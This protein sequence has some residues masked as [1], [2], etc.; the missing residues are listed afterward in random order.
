MMGWLHSSLVHTPLEMASSSGMKQVSLWL[1][2]WSSDTE[3]PRQ[4]LCNRRCYNTDQPYQTLQSC[5]QSW[6]KRWRH[7]D[8]VCIPQS[9]RNLYRRNE[10]FPKICWEE[11]REWSPDTT[12]NKRRGTVAAKRLLVA[13]VSTVDYERGFSRQNLIKTAI[14]NRINID[15]LDNLMMMSIEGPDRKKIQLPQSLPE[16]GVKMWEEDSSWT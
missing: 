14:R 9:Q 8:S 4:I 15:N 1:L 7:P 2:H 10:V 6:W 5:H 3:P 11:D 13:P 12:D 16:V